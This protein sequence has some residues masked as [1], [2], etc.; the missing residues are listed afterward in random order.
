MHLRIHPIHV[1]A[2]FVGDHFQRQLVVIAEKK[3]PLAGFRNWR[4][5]FQNIHDGQPVFHAQCHEQTRHQRKMKC[6]V[7]R[8]AAAAPKINH[9][10]VRPL[11]GL[12]N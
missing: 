12:G 4:R 10:V 3:R 9:R 1:I 7:A 11:I 8:V 2:L 5:L 6:H